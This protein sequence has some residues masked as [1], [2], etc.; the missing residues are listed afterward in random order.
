MSRKIFK[1]GFSQ[2]ELLTTIAVVGC[3]L[4]LGIGMFNYSGMNNNIE[5]TRQA[6]L[7]STLRT[8]TMSIIGK[9]NKLPVKTACNA[10]SLR[11]L[12]KAKISGAQEATVKVNGI[13]TPAL[14]V[15]NL[16]TIAICSDEPTCINGGYV[17][18]SAIPVALYTS[19][20]EDIAEL[21]VP[22]YTKA[23]TPTDMFISAQDNSDLL[24]S[25]NNTADVVAYSFS[26]G[27]LAETYSAPTTTEIASLN[28]T[29]AL[30]G[31]SAK[32]GASTEREFANHTEAI[33]ANGT[34]INP[35]GDYCEGKLDVK[36][37]QKW[38][39]NDSCD[40]ELVTCL[41]NGLAADGRMILTGQVNNMC[42]INSTANDCSCPQSEKWWVPAEYYTIEGAI[43]K[44][45][46]RHDITGMCI[47][48]CKL[49]DPHMI[50][51]K[52]NCK[53]DDANEY[54][55]DPILKKCV[56]PGECFDP[57][58]WDDTQKACICNETYVRAHLADDEIYTG[59]PE[60]ECKAKCDVAH[61]PNPDKDTCVPKTCPECLKEINLQDGQCYC[62]KEQDLNNA[63]LLQC[64]VTESQ[65]YTGIGTCT[66][67]CRD[68]LV[69]PYNSYKVRDTQ[70][71]TSCVCQAT[72]P[73]EMTLGDYEVYDPAS[74]MTC[75]KCNTNYPNREYSNDV[76]PGE[77]LCKDIND[78]TLQ[79][80]A[81]QY[82]DPTAANC[83]G[84]CPQ[85]E[86]PTPD[87]TGCQPDCGCLQKL[88][89][90]VCVCNTE[91]TTAEIQA[92]KDFHGDIFD[93][94]SPT[95]QTPCNGTSHADTTLKECI[96][97]GCAEKYTGTTC[98]CDEA[99]S[100]ANQCLKDDEKY[101]PTVASC[102]SC[103]SINRNYNAQGVCE[104]K[105]ASQ[106][107][108]SGENMKYDITKPD[109]EAPC[110]GILIRNLNTPTE[111]KCPSDKPSTYIVPAG[112]H[113]NN[114]QTGTCYSPCPVGDYCPGT[115]P[116]NPTIP[117]I[118]PSDPNPTIDT[119]Y[120]EG[121]VYKCPCGTYG[122]STGLSRAI[123][124]S[125]CPAGTKCTTPGTIT[126][127]PCS[128]AELCLPGTMHQCNPSTCALP[129]VPNADHTACVCS[130]S[131]PSAY[132]LPA[133][134]KYDANQATCIKP[135]PAG[136]YCPGSK[137]NDP[138]QP[139]IPAIGTDPL[140]PVPAMDNGDPFAYK[141]P[142]GKYSAGSI[143]SKTSACMGDCYKGYYC[144]KGSTTP[145]QNECTSSQKCPTGLNTCFPES[146]NLP[147][148]PNAD[149]TACVC[150]E[151]KPAAYS[152]PAGYK[153][154]KTATGC[155]IPCPA[156]DY[157]PGSKP[158]YP[159]QPNIPAI[160]SDPVDPSPI[161]DNNDPFAYK[162]P[163]GKYSSGS[164]DSKTSACLGDCTKGYYCTKGS[165][166]ATQNRCTAQQ[167][168]PTG[169][170][171]CFP[172]ECTSPY[173][174]N[175]EQTSC[176]CGLSPIPPAG[177]FFKAD[178]CQYIDCPVGHYCPGPNPPQYPNPEEDPDYPGGVIYC[179][180]GMYQDIPGSSN[181]KSD[182]MLGYYCP[183]GSESNKGAIHNME[184][185]CTS[186]QRCPV[187]TCQ[188]QECI[189]PMVPN[190]DQTACV[191][192]PTKPRGYVIRAGYR[193]SANYPA[194]GCMAPCPAGD[195][196]PGSNPNNP[197]IPAVD[198]ADPNPII[199]GNDSF[200]LK[201]PCGTY[202]SV[203]ALSTAACSGKCQAGYN[204]PAGSTSA[205]QNQCPT[206]R[207]C[208]EGICQPQTCS[209]PTVPNTAHT[210]CVCASTK[211]ANFVIPAR[212]HYDANAGVANN[213]VSLCPQGSYCPGT[214]PNNPS[215][216]IVDPT[217]PNPVVNTQFPA[218]DV[219][220]CPCGNY[221]SV[222]GL[223]AAA[224]SGK[225]QAGY[226]CPAGSTSATQ[227][228]CPTDRI[229]LEGICQPQ[230]C[231]APTVPNQ[232]H[233]ACVCASTKPANFVIPARYHYDANAGVANGCLSLCPVGSYCPGTQ[234]N[235]PSRP[236]VDPAD[237]NPIVNPNFPAGD[238]LKCPC[239]NYGSIVGLSVAACSGKCQA[240]YNC[241]AGSTSATQ[242]KCSGQQLCKEGICQIETCQLPMIPDVNH[243]ACIC[244]LSP[245]E[246]PAG[247]YFKADTCEY[248]T[249]PAGHYCPGSNPD[250]NP[251]PKPDPNYP[252]G[253][254]YCPCGTFGQT[255]GLATY[256]CSGQCPIG[257][258]CP[259]GTSNPQAHICHAGQSCHIGTCEPDTC[260]FPT[261]SIAPFETC[262]Q[263]MT[264]ANIKKQQPDY[265]KTNEV[266]INDVTKACKKCKSNMVPVQTGGC[267]CPTDK[268]YWYNEECN[269]CENWG[270]LY[271]ARAD[272]A[273]LGTSCKLGNFL[274][275]DK[276]CFTG[277]DG[278]VIPDDMKAMADKLSNE[279]KNRTFDKV[280]AY[281]ISENSVNTRVIGVFTVSSWY[282]VFPKDFISD[283]EDTH[284]ENRVMKGTCAQMCAGI[285]PNVAGLCEQTC[286][287]FAYNTNTMFDH[288]AYAVKGTQFVGQTF[289]NR[290]DELC[291]GGMIKLANNCFYDLGNVF[292]KRSSP[293][294]FDLMNDG[295]AYT[296][297]EEGVVF[298]LDKDGK[299][300]KT[301][302]TAPQTV[303]DNAFLI[304]DKNKN[305]QVDNGGELFG[306][307][308]GEENGFKELAKYDSN[309][310]KVI[311]K[312][313]PI[314]YE[315]RLWADMNVNAKIDYEA[316]GTS[317][318]IKTLEEAGIT[319][320]S[321]DYQKL[322]DKKGN[323]LEDMYGNLVG[324]MGQFKM[325]VQNAAG[326]LVE[327]VRKV[328][329]VF[330]VTQ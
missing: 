18:T 208:L 67:D 292:R 203:T 92:C 205:T 84:T 283:S 276:S 63:A 228:Q 100:Q 160:G 37:Y 194:D 27:G 116:N 64:G 30:V 69:D 33:C 248:V 91:I 96:C 239:G 80:D 212:Y 167:K 65:Y 176:V 98:V 267:A 76:G 142:C 278:R 6:R 50:G 319:E 246:V 257:Y 153:Y 192:A 14:R 145:T 195:Y 62:K 243:T 249:C 214:Q 99:T 121:D 215:Q 266:W 183:K 258:Y 43:G 298:D 256:A 236:V 223:S 141:C 315:L 269:T 242:N 127:V 322:L 53:C 282:A 263:C 284:A 70:N 235:N 111:C 224:C 173:I 17:G 148:V 213:C 28:S 317:K 296:S 196:C 139:N 304:L 169:L 200:T 45:G 10:A 190:A 182:C 144:T 253:V 72:K 82:Y 222:T 314:Y 328:M 240:G 5:Q 78:P 300:E 221:G 38:N 11:G 193:Y 313:D 34:Y 140:D 151:T 49:F 137:P 86:V 229:C 198:P 185:K 128:G 154:D 15:K 186:A 299:P 188:P 255:T 117:A 216:P 218:G 171:T 61:E 119:T 302:W 83:V 42:A 293:L 210:A 308:N 306:D 51:V 102:K 285:N 59:I 8:A 95:C 291:T 166:S 2:T 22:E 287:Q 35:A 93:P 273:S 209:L 147:M 103:A 231:N 165:T 46:K 108:F 73:A 271:F 180:C 75:R 204:C 281:V 123:C 177:K 274:K 170:N 277:S 191:C 181:C 105:P 324:I 163:C 327:T 133:G 199:D 55:W 162:C 164:T 126:P 220:K 262:N 260:A 325:M 307:Q 89:N 132:S 232:Q 9:E 290:S 85:G 21:T 184:H 326:K 316:D 207:I 251:D 295:F 206:D 68:T 309:G 250:A 219:L 149:Q 66:G 146:C 60:D 40:K 303:F 321:T 237:P 74:T 172:E 301:A 156:G 109:C 130:A 241:P 129:M 31:D 202:G 259:Q 134:Y 122:A 106:I 52:G 225:C 23:G 71:I 79:M 143:D 1:K 32:T 20:K 211:P 47:S 87:R 280:F 155:I 175:E 179:P 159:S 244:G 254:I 305:G 138:S 112:N 272:I 187:G 265:F 29:P 113:Y 77:C 152:L 56:K 288:C 110:D 227:N 13:E 297:V 97:D 4:A 19:P 107:I 197:D 24:A 88:V 124:T 12:L 7:D 217:D 189:I 26:N 252:T 81:N 131:K 54:E 48:D 168:C 174:P 101:D 245:N 310:D 264:E 311:N 323:V 238:V 150:A 233:T 279:D 115:N 58:I 25:A 57:F 136:D 39:I 270:K 90:G 320:I 120:P 268:P 158:G 3:I 104:C 157:C 41:G 135:C 230:E 114:L 226:N 36:F 312:E 178:T 44:D 125:T 330:F 94:N 201:C 161:M 275:G 318:E 118:D 247:K 329:D 294:V 261:T 289:G 234:P 16:G 286:K